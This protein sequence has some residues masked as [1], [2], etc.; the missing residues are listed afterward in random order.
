MDTLLTI[1]AVAGVGAAVWHVVRSGFRILRH[2][3]TGLWAEELARTRARRGDVTGVQ[4][5]RG[6]T[7]E[8]ARVRRRVVMEGAGWLVL[9]VVPA[10]T[11][12]ARPIYAV[13]AVL[14]AMPFLRRRSP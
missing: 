10:L 2:G 13:Y 5:S 11:P 1:L 6:R 7:E 3:A 4:E 9:L 8:I 14:W 12:W